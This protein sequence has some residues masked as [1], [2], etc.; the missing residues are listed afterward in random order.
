MKRSFFGLVCTLAL[1]LSATTVE[2]ALKLPSIIRGNGNHDILT[3]GLV[4]I[5][6]NTGRVVKTELRM[7]SGSTPVSIITVY[8]FDEELG[9]NVPVEMR[10]WYPEGFNELR[11]VATYGRF[12]RF[13]VTTTEELK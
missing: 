6:E 7:G 2:A 3:R 4:W 1:L 12:R 10:D 5:D 8:K 11:G 9:I 13:Q